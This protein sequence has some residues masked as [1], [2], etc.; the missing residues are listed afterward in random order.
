MSIYPS[1]RVMPYVYLLVH[2]VTKQFYFGSR[3]GK[4]VYLSKGIPSHLDLPN[5][6]KTSSKVISE[7]GFE[8]FDWFILAEFWEGDDAYDFEQQLIR[9][10]WDNELLLN[11]HVVQ[12]GKRRFRRAKPVT[13]AVKK[14]IS[15]ALKGRGPRVRSQTNTRP[16]LAV[17]S[18]MNIAPH[19]PLRR[20]GLRARKNRETRP[21]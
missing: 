20:S 13:E 15:T 9:D 16:N 1:G 8:N 10:N 18:Q 11:E 6:Y 3:Y 4:K 21:L 19:L 14:R 5:V 17:Q 7:M 2:R 12:E